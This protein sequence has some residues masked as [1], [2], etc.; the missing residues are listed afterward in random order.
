MSREKKYTLE[1]DIHKTQVRVVEISNFLKPYFIITA[2]LKWSVGCHILQVTK[3]KNKV[4]DCLL[5]ICDT[6]MPKKLKKPF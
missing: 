5:Y 2:L 6:K 3:S 1:K 4:K